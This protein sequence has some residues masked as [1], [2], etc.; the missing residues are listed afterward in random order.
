M[1]HNCKMFDSSWIHI[2]TKTC[3]ARIGC[4]AIQKKIGCPLDAVVDHA[5]GFFFEGIDSEWTRLWRFK[6][7]TEE[8]S[9]D[10]TMSIRRWSSTG[11]CAKFR[12][13][14]TSIDTRSTQQSVL[15][16]YASNATA[17]MY[18]CVC[19]QIS[20]CV[21][22]DMGCARCG[23]KLYARTRTPERTENIPHNIVCDYVR[24]SNASIIRVSSSKIVRCDHHAT[25]F[26]CWVTNRLNTTNQILDAGANDLLAYFFWYSA[27]RIRRI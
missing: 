1:L 11:A 27:T 19:G 10:E 7:N 12:R 14:H 26:E 3:I 9:C 24:L 17:R 16:E 4:L 18:E 25:L 8:C 21:A 15:I 20:G 2:H 23:S 6:W 13:D 5:W 22:L